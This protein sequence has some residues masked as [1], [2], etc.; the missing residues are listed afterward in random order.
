MSHRHNP[1]LLKK[2]NKKH[3]GS[4]SSKRHQKRLLGPGKVSGKND[5]ASGGAVGGGG[6]KVKAKNASNDAR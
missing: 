3:K 4:E 5:S 1:G 6:G 2:G